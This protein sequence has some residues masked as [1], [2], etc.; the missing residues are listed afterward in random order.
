VQLPEEDFAAMPFQTHANRDG[1]T[2]YYAPHP[3][4]G[5]LQAMLDDAQPVPDVA[6][7]PNLRVSSGNGV[8]SCLHKQKD[9]RAIYFFANSSD[10]A[11]DTFVRLRGDLALQLWNP[12]TGEKASAE[13]ARLMVGGQA[14]TRL[15][16]RLAP[17]STVFAVAP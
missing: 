12:H 3:T 4:V 11:V 7:D 8:L 16:L 9:G 2:A 1:G 10:D 14:V 13:I 15:H 5:T 17:V 6:F